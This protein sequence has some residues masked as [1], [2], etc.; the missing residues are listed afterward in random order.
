MKTSLFAGTALLLV[1]AASASAQQMTLQIQNGQVT[2]DAQNV[3]V[4]Q[5]LAEWAR[6]GGAR[7][8]NAEKVGGGPVTLQLTAMPE[9]Q[10]IDTILR[11][12]GGYMLAPRPAGSAGVSAFDRIL[13]LPTSSAP[14]A[15][16]APVSAGFPGQRPIPQQMPEPVQTDVI[17]DEDN[18]VEPEPDEEGGAEVVSPPQDGP[19]RRFQRGPTVFPNPMGGAP[20][21]FVPQPNFPGNTQPVDEEEQPMPE[22]QVSPSNPFGVPAGASTSPGVI[23]PVPQQQQRPPRPPR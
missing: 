1:T 5:I 13:I 4:R 10:A 2:L 6:V 8:V 23:S 11:G 16:S 20:Q 22:P 15:S 14:R 17:E 21:P 7:I 9:R 12:V 19:N 18:D 3:S